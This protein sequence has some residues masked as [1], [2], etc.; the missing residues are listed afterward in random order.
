MMMAERFEKG[1]NEKGE[2][3]FLSKCVLLQSAAEF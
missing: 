1:K 3:A 2:T